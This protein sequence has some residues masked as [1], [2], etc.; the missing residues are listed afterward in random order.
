M[1]VGVS[2]FITSPPRVGRSQGASIFW[3]LISVCFA[4][5][6]CFYYWKNVE[7]EKN[8]NQMRDQVLQLREENETLSSQ[9]EHL[10]ASKAETETQLKTRE[11]LIQE[12]EAQ[13]A[14]EE[15]ALEGMGRQTQSQTQQNLAQVAMVKK[16]NE[17]IRKI[18][19]DTPPDVVERAGRPVLRVPSADLFAPGDTTLKPEGKAELSQI[20][21]A[22][23]GQLDAFELRV[24]AYSDTDAEA[25]AGADAAKKDPSTDAHAAS[26]ALTAA[27]AT[28]L[29]RFFRDQTQAPFLNVIV[30]GR[31]DAEPIVSNGADSHARNRRV[32]IT[33]TP[34][35]VPFH[36]PEPDKPDKANATSAPP[37][38]TPVSPADATATPA[39]KKPGNT[40]TGH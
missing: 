38:N 29:S 10:E 3:G 24:V 32:E 31:G 27:R 25:Q 18:G 13:L 30:T 4:F 22:I 9:K 35:P 26:W 7:S 11:E 23:G 12:K 5:A 40:S 39:K 33:V 15:T 1:R 28:A 14:Q 20:V 16:F 8:A 6:A 37:K 19:K 2:Y 17:V 34:L 21:Q 36:S